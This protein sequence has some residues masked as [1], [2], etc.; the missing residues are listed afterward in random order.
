MSDEIAYATIRELGTRYR[1]REMSPVEVTR[2]AQEVR[3]LRVMMAISHT[4][5]FMPPIPDSSTAARVEPG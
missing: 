4:I 1:Q 5:A 3:W 2:V